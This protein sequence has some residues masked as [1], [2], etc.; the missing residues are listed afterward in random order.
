M[1]DSNQQPTAAQAQTQ[2]QQQLQFVQP[3]LFTLA[4]GGLHVSYATSGIDG[5]PRLTYQSPQQAL[6]F[7]G[8]EIRTAEVQDLGLMVVSVTIVPSVDAGTTTFSLLVPRMNLPAQ[9]ATAPIR[10]DGITTHHAFSIVQAFNQGQRDFYT[11]TALHG[12]ASHVVF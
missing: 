12:T 10:T 8:D 4:G 5:K 2:G 7:S 1:S 11:V 3:N 9:F 6:S